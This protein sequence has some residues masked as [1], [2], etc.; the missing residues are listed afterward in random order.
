MAKILPI[1]LEIPINQLKK[2]QIFQNFKMFDK[3]LA[4][5][6]SKFFRKF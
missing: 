4:L 6:E 1:W 2:I 5:M 3:K